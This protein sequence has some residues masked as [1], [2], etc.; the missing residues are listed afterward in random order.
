M[1]HRG[2][3]DRPQVVCVGEAQ[4]ERARFYPQ[5]RPLLEHGLGELH[6]LNRDTFVLMSGRD[7][8]SRSSSA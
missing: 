5:G 6:E 2:V 4:G 7:V 8:P 1:L 3:R